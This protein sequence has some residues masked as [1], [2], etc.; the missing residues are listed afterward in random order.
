MQAAAASEQPPT[1]NSGTLAPLRSRS[2]RFFFSA[3]SWYLFHWTEGRIQYDSS[4]EKH[5]LYFEKHAQTGLGGSSTWAHRAGSH[6]K[7]A[8][9]LH[10]LFLW[11][12]LTILFS[13]V[14]E[15]TQAPKTEQQQS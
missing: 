6:R 9:D 13:H 15:Y 14:F 5:T 1:S 12:C 10:F 4:P 8:Y 11:V 7:I 2:A 3:T